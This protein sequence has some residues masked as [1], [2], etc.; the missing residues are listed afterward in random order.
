MFFGNCENAA[1]FSRT[2]ASS[3]IRHLSCA[4]ACREN[5]RIKAIKTSASN[6]ILP[7]KSEAIER[8]F[9][10]LNFDLVRNNSFFVTFPEQ[11][12]NGLSAAISVIER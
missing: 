2:V 5:V 3:A 6:F 10:E 7:H 8:L 11:K 12:F 1:G 4:F 9:G